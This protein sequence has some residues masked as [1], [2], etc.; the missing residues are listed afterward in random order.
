MADLS[1]KSMFELFQ[2]GS[3]RAKG[4]QQ[5][6]VRLFVEE[7]ERRCLLSTGIGFLGPITTGPDGKIWFLEK[8]RLGRNRSY[9]R[10]GRCVL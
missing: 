1:E 6:S 8:D 4:K 7:L 2:I 10:I 9:D 5:R 3:R